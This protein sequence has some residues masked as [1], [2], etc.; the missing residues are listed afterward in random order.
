MRMLTSV[1]PTSL[2][3]ENCRHFMQ[4]GDTVRNTDQ[5]PLIVNQIPRT[6]NNPLLPLFPER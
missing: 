2:Y 3:P 1:K 6:Q 5:M 4:P